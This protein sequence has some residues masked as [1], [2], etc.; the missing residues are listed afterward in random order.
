MDIIIKNANTVNVFTGKIEKGEVG[1]SNGKIVT[2]SNELETEELIKKSNDKVIKECPKIIDAEGKYLIPG[3]ID[4]HVHI[5]SSYMIPT[6][7]APLLISCGT[8]MIVADP[9]EITS[10][11][12]V[13]GILYMF[14]EA[15]RTKLK[16]YFTMPYRILKRLISEGYYEKYSRVIIGLG[17]VSPYL[18][19]TEEEYIEACNFARE[20]GFIIEGHLGA[21]Y[22]DRR[23]DEAACLGVSSCHESINQEEALKKLKRGI[24]VI[25][26]EGSAAKNLEDILTNIKT[27]VKDTRNMLFGTDDLEILDIFSKGHIDNCLRK[28]VKVG[29]DPIEAI[30][31]ATINAAKHFK[32]DKM[33]GSIAPGKQADLVLINNLSDF[34]AEM[35][36]IEGDIVYEGGK[37]HHRLRKAQIPYYLLDSIKVERKLEARDFEIVVRE[38]CKE[39]MVRVIGA[40]NG[41]ITSKFIKAKLKVKGGNVLRDLEND[42]LKIAVIDRYKPKGKVTVGFI[43]SFCLKEGAIATSIA[44]DEHNILVVGATDEDMA[45][46]ANE[47]INMQGGLIVVNNGMV[48]AKVDL[49]IAGLMTNQGP[50]ELHNDVQNLHK[51]V[52]KLGIGLESPF[53]TLSFLCLPIPELKIDTKGILDV[54]KG[55]YVSPIESCN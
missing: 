33:I 44:H 53:M 9:H 20:K 55:K 10:V 41:Q 48:L 28:A 34:N 21:N 24:T 1:I 25:V 11:L 13:R 39:A 30:Q 32:L 2:I 8:T 31:I 42:I 27:K 50:V 43:N 16:I 19:P 7:L 18:F 52:E 5:E 40:I 6:T 45:L 12:D 15:K 35:V 47:I 54:Y 51:E 4:S 36:M 37:F 14:E 38:D 17:E 46:A 3:L 49:P 22:S 26:R 29:L 23:L